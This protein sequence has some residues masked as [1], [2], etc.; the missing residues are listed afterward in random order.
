MKDR[1]E[2]YRDG[3]DMNSLKHIAEISGYNFNYYVGYDKDLL[4]AKSD[5]DDTYYWYLVAGSESFFIGHS[6]V[7]NGDKLER[8]DEPL[9]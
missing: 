6:Y 4:F 3:M 9:F 2:K 5:D 7:S 1:L 8:A